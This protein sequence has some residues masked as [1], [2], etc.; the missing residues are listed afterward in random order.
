MPRLLVDGT[1]GRRLRDEL[2]LDWFEDDWLVELG[3]DEMTQP[4]LSR[5]SLAVNNL[6]LRLRGLLELLVQLDSV[7]EL[8]SAAR[9]L[10]VLDTDVDPL[11]KNSLFDSLVDDDAEGV[12][13]HIVDNTGPAVIHL[14][15]HTFL[16]CT[17]TTYVDYVS[18][19]VRL[20][21]R[22]QRDDTSRAELAREQVTRTA[23]ISL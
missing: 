11:R 22:R 5:L 4:R 21:V 13:R 1:T 8:L 17:I 18:L 23:P 9:V 3:A 15:W 20:H 2:V 16:H 12:L 19:L 6:S 7:E 14:V 10:D